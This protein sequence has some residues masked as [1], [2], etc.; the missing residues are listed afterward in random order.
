MKTVHIATYAVN[1]AEVYEY[2]CSKV[3]FKLS[4]E[5]YAKIEFAF[6]RYY[7]SHDVMYVNGIR[8]AVSK[9]LINSK[10]VV[11]DSVQILIVDLMMDCLEKMGHLRDIN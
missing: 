2:V 4:R 6:A 5:I 3:E 11:G 9:H 10:V 7:E 1:G 8:S